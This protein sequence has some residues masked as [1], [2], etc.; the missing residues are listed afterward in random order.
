[1]TNASLITFSVKGYGV[2]VTHMA[3]GILRNVGDTVSF[4]ILV[5]GIGASMFAFRDFDENALTVSPLNSTSDTTATINFNQGGEHSITCSFYKDG[6]QVDSI[7]FTFDVAMPVDENGNVVQPEQG[8]Q[9][10]AGSAEPYE[11]PADNPDVIPDP[12]PPQP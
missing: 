5:D 6:K 11:N 7:T 3:H 1:V 8:G 4:D 9:A 12:G 10:P 2:D